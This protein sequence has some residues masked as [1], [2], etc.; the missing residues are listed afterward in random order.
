[1]QSL[2]K[3][4]RRPSGTTAKSIYDT[5]DDITEEQR[6]ATLP[7]KLSAESKHQM[8]EM[9]EEMSLRQFGS[10]TDLLSKLR[11][12]LRASFPRWRDFN[13]FPLYKCV[14][15]RFALFSFVQEF[16]AGP[17]DGVSLLLEVLRAIQLSQAGT[18]TGTMTLNSTVAQRSSPTYQRRALLDELAC[19]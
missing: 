8:T 12:D 3:Y 16:V 4:G 5:A 17:L 11:A 14:T 10:V 13:I 1:M 9:G 18:A 7:G 6:A 19:L 15:K 2:K